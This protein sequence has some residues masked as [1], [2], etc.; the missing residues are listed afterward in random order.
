MV[1][2]LTALFLAIGLMLA[3]A[4]CSNLFLQPTRP[5]Y[6]TPERLKVA[7]RDVTF[8]SEDGTRLHG[9]WL[10]SPD[11]PKATI[12]FLHG[13]AQNISTHALNVIWLPALGYQV[14][15]AD[16]R[17]YGHSAGSADL[18]GAIMDSRAMIR[19]GQQ[20]AGDTPCIVMGQSLGASLLLYIMGSGMGSGALTT[21]ETTEKIAG[22]IAI[23]AFGDYRRIARE[24]AAQFWL[25][26]PWQWPLS[27]TVTNRYRPLDRVAA[28]APLPLFLLHSPTDRVIPFDHA[29]DLAA[30]RPPHRLI[31]LRGG[32]NDG[33]AYLGNRLRLL[34][35][36]AEIVAGESQ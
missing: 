15:I 5:H 29:Q 21:D 14:F 2:R 9:W 32:H 28:I 18:D 31:L 20:L 19:Q 6:L 10:P 23:A 16:Y 36:L 17:G 11:T 12:V 34:A 7:Y 24:T 30:A 3:V 4:G 26:W 27:L 8:A 22:V 35:V 33:L 13:N 1:R 25:T